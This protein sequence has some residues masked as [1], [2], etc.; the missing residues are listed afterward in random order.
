MLRMATFTY[1][2][3]HMH[4]LV[5]I[6]MYACVFIYLETPLNIWSCMFEKD[7]ID[8]EKWGTFF[9]LGIQQWEEAP[10][11]CIS[12]HGASRFSQGSSA[13]WHRKR[14]QESWRST[15]RMGDT[16]RRWE[17]REKAN[18]KSFS[19]GYV[20]CPLAT[21]NKWRVTEG[22]WECRVLLQTWPSL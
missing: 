1:M 14:R 15:G 3:V 16:G 10:D 18:A 11:P 8:T 20:F 19:E 7:F 22:G 4:T 2:Y 21:W 5:L 12:G 17:G 9:V 13:P 6:C